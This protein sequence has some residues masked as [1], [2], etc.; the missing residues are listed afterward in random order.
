MIIAPT[1]PSWTGER[2]LSVTADGGGE[3]SGG[4]AA[5]SSLIKVRYGVLGTKVISKRH[6]S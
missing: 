2:V 1:R 4:V 6:F 5:L 3:W